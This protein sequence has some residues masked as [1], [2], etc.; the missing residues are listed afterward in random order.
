[1]FYN[2]SMNEIDELVASFSEKLVSEEIKPAVNPFDERCFKNPQGVIKDL[3]GQTLRQAKDIHKK[4][5]EIGKL[6]EELAKF[7]EIKNLLEEKDEVELKITKVTKK[8]KTT[9][10]IE[11]SKI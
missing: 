10:K 6:T 5:K 8:K 9:Y 1:M 3:L 4:N 2:E 7:A 11:D